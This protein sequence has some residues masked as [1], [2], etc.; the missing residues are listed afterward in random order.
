M[1]INILLDAKVQL[2]IKCN[3]HK[4]HYIYIYRKAP[5]YLP[6]ST[7]KHRNWGTGAMNLP[8]EW[9][10]QSKKDKMI[11]TNMNHPDTSAKLPMILCEKTQEEGKTNVLSYNFEC[12]IYI[13]IY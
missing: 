3:L 7:P 8:L 10:F 2:K 9:G 4:S 12:V 6:M 11:K 5:F 1:R 13:Y